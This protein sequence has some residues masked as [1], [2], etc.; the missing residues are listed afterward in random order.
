MPE[1]WDVY[2]EHRVKKAYTHQRGIP[3]EGTDYHLV[4]EIWSFTSDGRVLLT[5]RHPNK[6]YGSSWECTGGSALAGEDS[7]T[8][9]HRELKEETGLDLFAAT[10]T[11]LTT[12]LSPSNHTIYDIY[13][14][15]LDFTLDDVVLQEGETVDKRLVDFSYLEDP[16]N[17]A[18][19]ASP[20]AQRLHFLRP[21]LRRFY[22]R[23]ECWDM[24]NLNGQ[25]LGYNR[26]RPHNVS[27]QQ[28]P[29]ECSL[30]AIAL[31]QNAE[32]QVLLTRRAPQKAAAL[33]W[34]CTGGGVDTGE[35]PMQALIRET[36]E[37]IGLDISAVQ[38]ILLDQQLLDG[39]YGKWRLY[40][41]RVQLPFVLSDLVFQPEEVVD[42][43]FVSLEKL[44]DY[45]LVAGFLRRSPAILDALR[46]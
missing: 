38:P 6:H 31:I 12:H 39:D 13:A 18:E 21:F 10:P 32:G 3:L 2:D 27:E 11:L 44:A 15:H 19:L 23:A 20:V 43:Q 9:V 5:L 16:A 8:A 24:Y 37:E 25:F 33:Q 42:A 36:H 28:H 41:Y 29:W 26:L 4:V 40:I 35:T 7:L 46:P 45:P 22:K 14:V 34:G 17:E 30:T 1:I